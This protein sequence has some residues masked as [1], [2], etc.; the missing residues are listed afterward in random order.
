MRL[1]FV[2]SFF[3]GGREHIIVT[4]YDQG[5]G[6]GGGGGGAFW[7]SWICGNVINGTIQNSF[8][9]TILKKDTVLC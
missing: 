8:Y 6:G 2:I 9:V 1:I 7:K 5:G 4:I 3:Q